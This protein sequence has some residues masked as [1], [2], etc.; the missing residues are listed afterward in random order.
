MNDKM[1]H[2]SQR[3]NF[4]KLVIIKYYRHINFCKVE[5]Y[6]YDLLL[7]PDSK[8]FT[9]TSGLCFKLKIAHNLAIIV[10][11]NFVLATKELSSLGFLKLVPSAVFSLKIN[12][13]WTIML[14][15]DMIQP[16][17]TRLS[18]QEPKTLHGSAFSFFQPSNV[19]R[20]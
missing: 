9:F 11:V 8:G 4:P 17:G 13:V 1:T 12:D 10:S 18:T 7:P 3:T 16:L 6:I 19:R 14:Y 5:I 2:I 15:L 20:K